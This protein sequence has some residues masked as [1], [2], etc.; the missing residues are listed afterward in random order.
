MPVLLAT[1]TAGR[2]EKTSVSFIFVNL[3]FHQTTTINFHQTSTIIN[4]T[5]ILQ[6]QVSIKTTLFL[7]YWCNRIRLY[8]T[9]LSLRYTH[10]TI[11]TALYTLH[12]T[13]CTIHIA[14]Y[15]LHYTHCTI[16]IALYTLHYTY[17]TIHIRPT[18]EQ[19]T[20]ALVLSF[21]QRVFWNNTV[22]WVSTS[23]RIF[24]LYFY[25]LRSCDGAAS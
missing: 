15:T 17:C 23:Y 21:S 14:L 24:Y 12:N 8:K 1:D 20:K 19:N 6:Q 4:N 10:C 7:G 16:H 2:I 3:N 13:H 5:F 22:F 11:H 9:A 25:F 18:G